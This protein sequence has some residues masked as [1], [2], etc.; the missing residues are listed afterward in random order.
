MQTKLKKFLQRRELIESLSGIATQKT[1]G[2]TLSKMEIL[3]N[4]GF[5]M[6]SHS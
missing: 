4:L 2:I 6:H 1:D 3:I 5:K